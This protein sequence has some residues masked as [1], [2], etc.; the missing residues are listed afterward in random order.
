MTPATALPEPAH[1]AYTVDRRANLTY[2]EFAQA[3]LYANRPVVITDALARWKALERW[4]P[5]FF[6]RQFGDRKIDF[7]EGSKA[8]YAESQRPD[9]WTMA[10]FVD[11]VLQSSDE[12][13]APYFRNRI[14]YEEFP[15][16][17]DDVQPMP[18]YFQ[19]NWLPERYLFKGFGASMNRAA[20]IE[21][22]IGGTGGRFPT[23]H[24]DHAATHA[25]LMQVYGLKE[26]ILYSP[27]Q[28]RYL[29]PSPQKKNISLVNV[30]HPDLEKFPLFKHA[31]AS[32]LILNPGEMLFI[33]SHWWHTTKM[34][35]PCIS[36]S[37]NSVN[38]SNWSALIDYA[39][40]RCS[41]PL[42][43][44]AVRA[45]LGAAGARRSWR[46]RKWRRSAA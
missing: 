12:D 36:V 23:L 39:A 19:P 42:A 2:L 35:T 37:A 18:E 43:A 1:G 13:P 5:E 15:S 24:Y 14:L 40:W 7:G 46:D 28:D 11:K 31:Q 32:T 16:L 38:A 25:F 6:A 10:Q 21:L 20:A 4:S 29:Y 9:G 34:L 26:F 27:D 44:L 3:Y 8:K 30:E 41:N 17:K 22:Y 45:Y 33:P